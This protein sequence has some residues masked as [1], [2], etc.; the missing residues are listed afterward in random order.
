M[1]GHKI[2]FSKRISPTMYYYARPLSYESDRTSIENTKGAEDR[3][4][5]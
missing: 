1:T 2:E 5:Y 3:L 4:L